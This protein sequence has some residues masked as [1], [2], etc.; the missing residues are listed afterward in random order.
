MKRNWLSLTTLSVLAVLFASSCKP[1]GFINKVK[2]QNEKYINTCQT[3][4][5]EV[6]KT[7]KENNKNNTK[8]FTSQYDNSEFKYFY[9]EAGQYEI[10]KDTLCFRLAKDIP[11]AHYLDDKGTQIIV[12]VSYQAAKRVADMEV[13]KQGKLAPLVITKEYYFSH[14]KPYFYYRIP[15]NG[16]KLDG[17]QVSMSFNIKKINPKNKK[18]TIFCNSVDIPLGTIIPSCCGADVWDSTKLQS[19]NIV[20]KLEAKSESYTRYAN[21]SANVDIPFGDYETALTDSIFALVIQTY[22][23]KYAAQNFKITKVTIQGFASLSGNE[24]KNIE[25]SQQRA[26]AIKLAL[27]K[28]NPNLS[29]DA[30]GMGEDWAKAIIL[31]G[32]SKMTNEE[33]SQLLTYMSMKDVS[34]DVKESFMRALPYW[35]VFKETVLNKTRH[36]YVTMDFEYKGDVPALEKTNQSFVLGAKEI[37]ELVNAKFSV[38]PYKEGKTQEEI[39][40]ELKSVNELLGMRASANLYSLRATYFMAQKDMSKVISDLEKATLLDKTNKKYNEII[41]GIRFG[42]VEGMTFEQRRKMLDEYNKYIQE[43][44]NDKPLFFQRAIIMDKIGYISGA[45]NEYAKL[46]DENDTEAFHYNN[47]GVAKVRTFRFTEAESDFLKAL[48]HD[49]Q[50]AASYFNLAT[51]EA[52]R[53]HTAKTME[54]LDQAIAIDKKYK[55]LIFS[56]PVFAVM[57]QDPRFDKYR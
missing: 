30:K 51:I 17:K 57:A 33:K 40:K 49:N 56:N 34:N 37:E 24:P 19:V 48:K 13:E 23:D 26:E 43:N 16:A 8:L 50:M 5:E 35:A 28:N 3:F 18:E 6:G 45:L 29:I 53:G 10:R 44:P 14:N 25:L 1:D 11:Y 46:M 22:L 9:L 20:P 15:L 27:G 21:F 47:R 2:Y 41:R 52:F 39:Q 38:N 55:P 7:I 31:L 32:Q 42:E 54:Y 4:A 36:C 12:N